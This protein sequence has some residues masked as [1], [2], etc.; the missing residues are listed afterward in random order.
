MILILFLFGCAVAWKPSA[1][2]IWLV[3]LFAAAGGHARYGRAHH[4]RAR[5]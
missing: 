2:L 4:V 5:R 3:L 1:I